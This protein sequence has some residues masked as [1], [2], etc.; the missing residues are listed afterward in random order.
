MMTM[1]NDE[2]QRGNT[3]KKRLKRLCSKK[4]LTLVE[5]LVVLIVSSILLGCAM[6]MLPSVKN[7]LNSAKGNAHM[8]VMCDTAN[9]YIRGS[10]QSAKDVSIFVYHDDGDGAAAEVEFNALVDQ[11]TAYKNNLQQGDQI[12][13]IGVLKNF[14][15]D[16]RLYD[17]GNVTD[18]EQVVIDNWG[19]AT[20]ISSIRT[21][22]EKRDGGGAPTDNGKNWGNFRNFLVFNEDFYNNGLSGGAAG[23]SYQ[24][25]FT[26]NEDVDPEGGASGVNYMT[27]NSQIFRRNGSVGDTQTYTPNNQLK[28]M[29]FKLLN[30]DAIMDRNASANSLVDNGDGTY[31]IDTSSGL[32]GVIMLYVTTDFDVKYAP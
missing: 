18:I 3:M 2:K 10:L 16:Y 6:G 17:F 14:P 23:Y 4:G 32:N 20:G 15:G 22:I 11:W 29:S 7:L 8:D 27:L 24:L 28:K 9:E 25:A 30:G 1:T 13:V 21:L 5:I 26:L 12:R 19:V 31:S